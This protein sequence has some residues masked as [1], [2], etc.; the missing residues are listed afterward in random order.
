[1][2]EMNQNTVNANEAA[3]AD[4]GQV[5]MIRLEK[6][7]PFKNHPFRV[8]DN[9]DMKKLADSIRENGVLNPVLVRPDGEDSYE[10]VSGHRR[11]HA[12]K[13]AGLYEIPAYVQEM[14]DDEATIAMVDANVQR[15]EIL[16]SERAFSLK[17]KMDAMRRQGARNDLSSDSTRSKDTSAT[18]WRRSETAQKVGENMRLGKSQV[19]K[20]V[21]L[22]ELI[23]EFMDMVDQKK[24]SMTM[25]VDIAGFDKDLQHWLYAYINKKGMIRQPQLDALKDTNTDNITER[26]MVAIL[27]ETAP[28]KK[29]KEDVILTKKQLDKYFAETVPTEKRA[30]VILDLLEKWKRRQD[31]LE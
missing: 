19:R 21:R 25:G 31:G 30:V 9:A 11:M 10:M 26:L 17:M 8:V 14:T 28:K 27:E 16:P 15:E 5:Q 4:R 18:Q 29:I 23:P 12:A 1:M 6:I 22:T 24:L 20:Y 13:Q 3:N 7:H 2:E